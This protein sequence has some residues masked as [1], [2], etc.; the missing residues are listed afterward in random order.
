MKNVQLTRR[1][2]L[3]GFGAG[4]SLIAL[5][6]CAPVPPSAAPAAGGDTA[7]APS[8][9]K[10]T[11]VFWSSFT[12]KNSETETE[13]VKRFNEGQADV[14]LDYQFQ[15]T[16]EETAQKVTAAL[17]AGTA[18]DFTLLSDVWWFKFYLNQT[19]LP[20]D[21]LLTA[22]NVDLTDYQDS[23]INEGL[24]QGQHWWIPFARSTPLFYYNKEKWAAAG[25][26]DRGPETWDEFMEWAP[27]LVEMDGTE[28]EDFGLCPSG[29]RQLHR[30]ALPRRRLAIWRQLQRSRLYHAPGRRKDRRRR[31]VLQRL[32]PHRTSG[33]ARARTSPP[34]SWVAL[35][36]LP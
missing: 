29:W 15:G 33:R 14:A 31:P 34:I 22:E 19:L 16:Y 28:A 12:G 13:L 6:A 25:L 8:A 32:C 36:P 7:A 27:K 18:P 5:A 4:A 11:A 21:D 1:Q 10:V 35:P 23:L 3:K 24:R 26:P 17:Q 30:L 2:M 20:L 9:E